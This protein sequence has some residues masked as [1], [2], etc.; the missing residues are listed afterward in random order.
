[1]GPDEGY[2]LAPNGMRDDS[3]DPGRARDEI[4]HGCFAVDPFGEVIVL[5]EEVRDALITRGDLRCVEG[6]SDIN[7]ARD[8]PWLAA[9]DFCAERPVAWNVRCKGFV[10]GTFETT[11]DLLVC[12]TCERLVQQ[13]DRTGLLNRILARVVAH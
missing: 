8:T 2:S 10:Q 11:G 5:T 6:I 3:F 13:G 7:I 1:M 9:C 4:G 12:D